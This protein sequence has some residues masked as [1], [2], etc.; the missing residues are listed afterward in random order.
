VRSERDHEEAGLANPEELFLQQLETI[1]RAIQLTCWRGSLREEE[2]EDFASYVRL[3]LIEKDY[4]VLR[5]YQRR[6]TFAAFISVVVR[7]MLLDYRIGL[8]GKWHASL[9]ARRLGERAIAI[10]ALLYRDGRTLSEVLPM[11]GRRWPDLTPEIAEDLVRRLPARRPRLREVSMEGV[12]PPAAAVEDPLLDADARRTARRITTI[13]RDTMTALDERDRLI[14]HLRFEQDLSI[15]EISR[16]LRTEQKPL[17]RRL[18]RVLKLLRLRI[19]AAGIS[20]T[21]IG[22]LLSRRSAAIDLG[23]D[24][25]ADRR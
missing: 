3:K 6:A 1:E 23:L 18:E 15:A 13:V 25:P 10:E 16:T 12:R 7:R 11:L 24:D 5:K 2:A 4:A 21:D 19:E 20:P 14:V 17:Y 8:W 9:E 22:E